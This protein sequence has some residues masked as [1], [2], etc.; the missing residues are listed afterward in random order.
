MLP[1]AQ[2]RWVQPDIKQSAKPLLCYLARR[3]APP[4]GV[5]QLQLA[6]ACTV[7]YISHCITHVRLQIKKDAITFLPEVATEDDH[8]VWGSR[9]WWCQ[10]LRWCSWQ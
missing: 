6:A 9:G 1:Y 3:S 5:P 2:S 7:C 10:Q 8:E 4:C